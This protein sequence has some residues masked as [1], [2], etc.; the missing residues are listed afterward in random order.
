[1]KAREDRCH[2]ADHALATFVHS[3]ILPDHLRLVFAML[4]SCFVP[5]FRDVKMG[6]EQQKIFGSHGGING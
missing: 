4:K 5:Q 1:V 3:G 2:N 6:K